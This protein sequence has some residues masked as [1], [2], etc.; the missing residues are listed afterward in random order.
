M[1]AGRGG[2]VQPQVAETL[3]AACQ[4]LDD[5]L[6]RAV[7]RART[8]FEPGSEGD[9]YRGLCIRPAE[10]ERLLSQPAGVPLLWSGR[11]PGGAPLPALARAFGLS[12]FDV[13][14]LLIALA[15]E[16]DLRY[17][18]LYAYLQ[19]DVTRKSAS[20]DLAL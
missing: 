12:P 20:V 3:A 16:L 4:R 2:G 14:V 19:D 5:A 7:A 1:A 6:A 13:D 10:V 18:R 17:Q 8:L 11:D 15:P 9:P